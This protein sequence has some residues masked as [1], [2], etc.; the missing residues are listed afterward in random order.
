MVSTFFFSPFASDG[1]WLF[2]APLSPL[3]LSLSLSPSISPQEHNP[4]E[5]SPSNQ[6]N[7]AAA[8]A[9]ATTINQNHLVPPPPSSSHHLRYMAYDL[10]S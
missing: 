6:T 3:S 1:G 7:D 8:A 4:E 5:W 9:A 10:A 2:V